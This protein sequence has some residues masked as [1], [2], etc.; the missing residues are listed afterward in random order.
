VAHV[1]QLDD[2]MVLQQVNEL[3]KGAGGVADGENPRR[4]E[5]SWGYR[6]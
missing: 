5:G 2:A 3:I 6:R 4:R 1:D